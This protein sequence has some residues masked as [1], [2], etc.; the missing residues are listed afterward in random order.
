MQKKSFKPKDINEI[1]ALPTSPLKFD[2]I[3]E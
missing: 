3:V 2:L 1:S